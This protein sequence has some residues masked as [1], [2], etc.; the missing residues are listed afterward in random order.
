MRCLFVGAMILGAFQASASR[1]ELR[2][3][4]AVETISRWG[5]FE[6]SVPNTRDYANPFIDVTLEAT[7][8]SPAGKKLK[9]LGFYDG[10]K[11]WRLRFM[12]D[13][14]GDW[15]YQAKFSDGSPGISGLFRCVSKSRF[16]GPLLVDRANPLWFQYADGTHA[17]LLAFHLWSLDA[18][19]EQTLGRTLDFLKTQGFNAIIG[20]HLGPPNRLPW[21]KKAD[22]KPDFSRF[23]LAVWAGLDRAARMLGNRGMVFI[24]FSIFGGTNGMPKIPTRD[25]EDLLLRYWVARWGGFWNVTFQ[26]TSEWEEGFKEDEIQRIGR[27]IRELDSGR[28]LVSVHSHKTASDGI[29]RSD[30]YDYHTVQDK[31]IDWNPTKYTWL[32]DLHR[33]VK[34]PILAHECLWEGNIYQKEAGLDVGNM[35]KAAWVI[36]LSGGQINYADEVNPPREFQ[37]R[38]GPDINYSG[39][40]AAKKPCGLFYGCLK[41]LNAFMR[42]LDL[43][44]MIVAPELSSTGICLA[45]P[46]EEYALYAIDGG[47]VTLDLSGSKGSFKCRWFNPRDGKFGKAFE[48]GGGKTV[49]FSAP[50]GNDWALHLKKKEIG[51]AK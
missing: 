21:E 29:Q 4:Q 25:E 23:N 41:A 50:D 12:P 51:K 26:P 42:S 46:G 22:G 38:G 24:P 19:D 36:A 35:R 27:M 40:G 8:T 14:P 5:L 2:L 49:Q 9:A 47:K 44:R 30:W 15:R 31:L 20:P 33:K 11:T 16:H 3:P 17:Y 39:L 13:S 28:H 1:A 48:V 6:I 37:R 32:V 10:D 18:M 7:F 34:K 45:K 43:R